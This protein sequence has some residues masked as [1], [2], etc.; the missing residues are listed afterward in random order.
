MKR[1][2]CVAIA[3]LIAL[4][5]GVTGARANMQ[6]PT[7]LLFHVQGWDPAFCDL[8]GVTRCEDLVQ[9]TGATGDLLVVVYLVCGGG[10]PPA[11]I[12][13]L[14]FTVQWGG[15]WWGY[16]GDLANCTDAEFSFED[17]YDSVTLHFD[18]PNHPYPPGFMPLCAFWTFAGNHS[19]IEVLGDGTLHWGYPE[20]WYETPMGGMAEAGVECEYTCLLDCDPWSSPCV[21]TLTPEELHFELPQGLV[22]HASMQLAMAGGWVQG[23]TCDATEPWVTL[24]ITE[25][26]HYSADI[27]VTANT[28]DLAVGQYEARVRATCDARDC[29]RIYLTVTEADP[30]AIPEDVP[31]PKDEAAPATWGGVKD[32]YR[33]PAR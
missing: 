5:I 26:S 17:N 32:L 23:C 3:G 22:G 7:M 31:P 2:R 9:T 30:Q 1:A 4:L 27:R 15:S 25:T 8:P 6:P 11:P 14:D 24:E 29:S 28:A 13:S 21:P 10:Y 20:G 12:S 16:Y 33:T 19:C 18:W